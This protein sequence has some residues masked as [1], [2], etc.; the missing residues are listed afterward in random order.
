MKQWH[1]ASGLQCASWIN[2]FISQR[3]LANSQSP[4]GKLSPRFLPEAPYLHIMKSNLHFYLHIHSNL[5]T[6]V[7]VP[8]TV[9]DVKS[10]GLFHLSC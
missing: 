8:S 1:A 5:V 10:H 6:S 7:K 3:P 2:Y 9:R 4:K